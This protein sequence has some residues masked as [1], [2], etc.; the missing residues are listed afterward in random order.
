M[1]LTVEAT[2]TLLLLKSSTFQ[3]SDRT[4]FPLPFYP[5]LFWKESLAERGMECGSRLHILLCFCSSHTCRAT[6]AVAFTRTRPRFCFQLL[7]NVAC[8]ERYRLICCSLESILLWGVFTT[9]LL[10]STA[11]PPSFSLTIRL[12]D[13]PL[14]QTHTVTRVTPKSQP[15][16]C[17]PAPTMTLAP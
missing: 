5:S 9:F 15:L 2:T 11:R 12:L 14:R 1:C 4:D 6:S 10:L 8:Q 3:D 7:S 13:F 17:I 16:S